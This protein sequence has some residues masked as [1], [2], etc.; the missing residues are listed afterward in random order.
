[1]SVV[2]VIPQSAIPNPQSKMPCPVLIRTTHSDYPELKARQLGE[3]S[4]ASNRAMAEVWVQTMLPDHFSPS[5]HYKYGYAPRSKRYM[6]RKRK[7]A[8]RGVVLDGGQ[9]DLVFT[10]RLRHMLTQIQPLIKSYPSRASA[11]L[12]G[13]PYFTDRPRNPRKPNMGREVTQ[14]LPHQ[15]QVL[16]GRGDQVFRKKADEIKA[17][18]T[19]ITQGP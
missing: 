16:A 4:R 6:D 11:I 5:A 14:I 13:T 7:L 17:T 3:A 12:F 2:P 15:E 18:K 10:G 1:M 19:V 9:T 8:A